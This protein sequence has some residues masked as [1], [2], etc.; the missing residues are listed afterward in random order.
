MQMLAQSLPANTMLIALGMRDGPTQ[1]AAE[2]PAQ[3]AAAGMAVVG[4]AEAAGDEDEDGDEV[5]MD[6]TEAAEATGEEVGRRKK[7]RGAKPP[8]GWVICGVTP[9]SRG[10]EQ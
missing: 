10:S 3:E 7:M 8:P 2:T 1:T 5:E 9:G 4:I 6:A